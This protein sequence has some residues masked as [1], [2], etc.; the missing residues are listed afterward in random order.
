MK[1][2]H[3]HLTIKISFAR[4]FTTHRKNAERGTL[5][6]IIKKIVP[7]LFCLFDRQVEIEI[8][9]EFAGRSV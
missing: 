5:G 1:I 9:V 6:E 8:D 7:L 3:N 4:F 2:V